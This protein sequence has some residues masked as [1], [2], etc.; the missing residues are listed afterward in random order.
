MPGDQGVS[1]VF[2]FPI[3]H[4]S[5][6]EMWIPWGLSF[7]PPFPISGSFS[8]LCTGPR[9]GSCLLSLFSV[10]RVSPHSLKGCW[11]DVSDGSLEK[12][13]F[14]H[15]FISLLGEKHTLAASWTLLPRGIFSIQNV[16]HKSY[17]A[18]SNAGFAILKKILLICSKAFRRIK[19]IFL[20]C[21]VL[22]S[23]VTSCLSPLVLLHQNTWGWVTWKEQEYFSQ[24]WRLGS[25]KSRHQH[26]L[27]FEPSCASYCGGSGKAREVKCLVK[28]LL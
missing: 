18:L 22:T 5:L 27:S 1:E 4:R 3:L 26:L 10:L 24:L 15:H 17:L 20:F 12:S 19:M 8:W 16:I 23:Q 21:F 13:V 28:S 9:L 11:H 25:A 7:S 14:T 2:A 6:W